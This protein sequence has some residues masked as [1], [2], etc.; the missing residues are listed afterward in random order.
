M[1]VGFHMNKGYKMVI[2]EELD[3]YDYKFHFCI[4]DIVYETKQTD[5]KARYIKHLEKEYYFE[6]V[7]N[8]EQYLAIIEMCAKT[9]F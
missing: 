8:P 5:S 3:V 1:L 9:T 7:E 2:I 4:D 6:E